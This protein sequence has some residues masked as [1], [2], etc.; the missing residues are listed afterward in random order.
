MNRPDRLR[1]S[2]HAFAV[3]VA[4]VQYIL[5]S[6]VQSLQRDRNRKFVYAEMARRRPPLLTIVVLT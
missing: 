2:S 5:D 1:M 6:V 4:G 3:Q